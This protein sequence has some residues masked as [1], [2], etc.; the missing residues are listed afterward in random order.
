MCEKFEIGFREPNF[1]QGNKMFYKNFDLIIGIKMKLRINTKNMKSIQRY[2]FQKNRY[3][4]LKS[5]K[6]PAES[7]GVKSYF[8]K[9]KI[10]FN[11]YHPCRVTKP[12]SPPTSNQL[13]LCGQLFL[14][15]FSNWTFW[16]KEFVN[17]CRL[18]RMMKITKLIFSVIWSSVN[19]VL[20]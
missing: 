16:I 3:Q 11:H 19:K 1:F 10:I 13:S 14:Q 12:K 9:L 17:Y 4:G 5:S 15:K 20:K 8:S 18:W 7:V 2:I 6:R